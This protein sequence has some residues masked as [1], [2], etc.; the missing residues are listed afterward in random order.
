VEEAY[1]PSGAEKIHDASSAPSAALAG[2]RT[3]ANYCLEERERFD[4]QLLYWFS[5]FGTVDGDITLDDVATAE[6]CNVS[7]YK[8]VVH[9]P[10]ESRTVSLAIS[11]LSLTELQD[12]QSD[13]PAR[14]FGFTIP[15]QA[16][17]TPL[18]ANAP[19]FGGGDGTTDDSSFT[20]VNAG[21]SNSKGQ[22]GMSAATPVPQQ[23]YLSNADFSQNES[24]VSTAY[25][26]VDYEYVD[27]SEIGYDPTQAMSISDFDNPYTNAAPGHTWPSMD[28]LSSPMSVTSYPLNHQGCA[29]VD[30]MPNVSSDAVSQDP[31]VIAIGGGSRSGKSANHRST[32]THDPYAVGDGSD[33]QDHYLSHWLTSNSATSSAASTPQKPYALTPITSSSQ[34]FGVAADDTSMPYGSLTNALGHRESGRLNN[35]GLHMNGLHGHIHSEDR[36]M[37]HAHAHATLA[38][39]GVH[40]LREEAQALAQ[41]QSQSHHM[42]RRGQRRNMN[43]YHGHNERERTD[44]DDDYP[45]RRDLRQAK[46]LP[47]PPTHY[48]FPSSSNSS[49]GIA[50]APP[51]TVSW[52]S[53]RRDA[54]SENPR[55]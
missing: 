16:L 32:Y 30:C 53:H 51:Q 22:D 8:A 9:T 23:G 7:V 33:L 44:R 40:R 15:S 10:T 17:S 34:V 5:E 11:L 6:L 3:Y 13:Q 55:K 54:A 21:V 50:S 47:P 45:L 43:A 42:S 4:Q 48:A 25:T 38:M 20:D 27:Y 29:C 41:A 24:Y 52:R 46:D 26:P 28:H 19:L 36:V 12:R 39:A 37:M 2:S 31:A 1:R 35:S 49:A 18:T 14:D